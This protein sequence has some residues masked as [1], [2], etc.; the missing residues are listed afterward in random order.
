MAFRPKTGNILAI[1]ILIALSV[2]NVYRAKTQSITYDEA[3]SYELWGSQPLRRMFKVYDAGNHVL[4]TLLARASVAV[5]GLSEFTLRLPSLLAGFL[6]FIA[7]YR[8]SSLVFGSGALFLLSVCVLSL[9]PLLLDLLSAA[10]GYSLALAFCAWALFY[11]VKGAAKSRYQLLG[12]AL[13]LAL[14][15]SSNITFLFVDA[16]LAAL[17]VGALLAGAANRKE[18]GKAALQAVTYFIVPGIIF[19][20]IIIGGPLRKAKKTDFYFGSPTLASSTDTLVH[21]SLIH[22]FTLRG[23]QY[24]HA[25]L[26]QTVQIISAWMIPAV[27]WLAGLAWIIIVLLGVRN[28]ELLKQRQDRLLF[29]SAGALLFSIAASYL[30]NK[31]TGLLYPTTRTGLPWIVFFLL[32]SLGLAKKLKEAPIALRIIRWPLLAFLLACA[33]WF[34][35]ELNANQYAEWTFDAGTKR[36][37]ALLQQQH[38]SEPDKNWQV[39]VSWALLPSLNYYKSLYHLN[40]FQPMDLQDGTAAFTRFVFAEKDVQLVQT[41]GLHTIYVDPVS[42][43]VLATR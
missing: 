4:E 23:L 13:L 9:N 28:K 17:F 37:V 42:S 31:A 27:L 7:V 30:A 10:R 32:V 15:V 29:F 11:M 25:P 38:Q 35:W 24:Y 41:L 20:L 43:Q 14:S 26:W 36:I 2:T 8:L 33:L 5:L 3:R 6:Y 39:C 40:W 19:T 34:V 1:L 16:G 21:I 22:R 12:L 18:M